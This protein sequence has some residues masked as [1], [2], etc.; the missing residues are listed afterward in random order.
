[1]KANVDWKDAL[2]E[3]TNTVELDEEVTYFNEKYSYIDEDYIVELKA[4]YE[5][6]EAFK[7]RYEADIELN[8]EL[9]MM[10]DAAVILSNHKKAKIQGA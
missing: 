3:A 9:E 4:Q 7:K 10:G 1:M 2:R 8:V 6:R 5:E